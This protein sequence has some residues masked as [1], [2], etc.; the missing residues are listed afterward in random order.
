VNTGHFF[1]LGIV[2][3]VLSRA[4]KASLSLLE[5]KIVRAS[6]PGALGMEYQGSASALEVAAA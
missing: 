5:L 2:L 3:L 6:N 4:D 1:Q